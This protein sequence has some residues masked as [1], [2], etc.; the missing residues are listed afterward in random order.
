MSFFVCLVTGIKTVDC[1]RKGHSQKTKVG[2]SA[3]NRQNFKSFLSP[4]VDF[5]PT[6]GLL[7]AV[8]KKLCSYICP[9][10]KALQCVS[11]TSIS[12]S[13]TLK[14]TRPGTHGPGILIPTIYTLKDFQA[15][16][17]GSGGGTKPQVQPSVPIVFSCLGC[18]GDVA[19]LDKCLPKSWVPLPAPHKSVDSFLY[20]HLLHPHWAPHNG[21]RAWLTT[22][23]V[24][25]DGPEP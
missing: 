23:Q 17:R 22:W 8:L 6:S 18:V 7:S 11:C 5:R 19:Q 10:L 2:Y 1:R 20:S 12:I 16:Q 15:G 24:P 21:M 13:K 25:R 9:T 4:Y 3:G 14:D